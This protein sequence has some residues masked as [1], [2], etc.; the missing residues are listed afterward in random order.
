MHRKMNYEWFVDD[1]NYELLKTMIWPCARAHIWRSSD[2]RMVSRV[3]ALRSPNY[4]IETSRIRYHIAHIDWL[5]KKRN[6]YIHHRIINSHRKIHLISECALAMKRNN[7]TCRMIFADE[8]KRR[9]NEEENQLNETRRRNVFL[10]FSFHWSVE[11][12]FSRPF[13]F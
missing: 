9:R 4:A 12:L 1:G 13:Q 6:D 10:L 5:K 2:Y 3:C 7:F 11:L 8:W